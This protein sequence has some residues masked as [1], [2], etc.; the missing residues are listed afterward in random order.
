MFLF[1]LE[2]SLW[3]ARPLQGFLR[4]PDENTKGTSLLCPAQRHTKEVLVLWL[5][6]HLEGV[7]GTWLFEGPWL[8]VPRPPVLSLRYPVFLSALLIWFLLTLSDCPCKQC[9]RPAFLNIG[10]SYHHLILIP[11]WTRII[12]VL[13]HRPGWFKLPMPL[14]LPH[15]WWHDKPVP[16][17]RLGKCYVWPATCS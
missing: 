16:P 17:R 1:K 2:V 9:I 7:K 13:C 15:K 3:G 10:M 11:P 14:P 4:Y 6:K 12:G 8:S 5:S